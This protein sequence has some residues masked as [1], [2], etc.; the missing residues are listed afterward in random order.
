MLG[1][2]E[3]DEKAAATYKLNHR[4]TCLWIQ[5]IRTVNIV[6]LS[7]QLRLRKGRLDLLAGCPPCQGFSAMRTLNGN[8]SIRDK[9]NDLVSEFLRFVKALRPRALML[10]NVPALAKS[11]RFKEL[12]KSLRELGYDGEYHIL[13]AANFGTPQRR[14]RLI[15]MAGLNFRP[16]FARPGRSARTVRDAIGSLRLAGRSGD[17]IHDIPENRSDE[18]RK[19]IKNI[20]RNGGGRSDLPDREQL[21]CHKLCNGFK[22]VYGRMEWDKPAPTITS[23]C[24]NPS[25]GRFLHPSR[26]RA[27]TV[28]EAALLQGFPES[29]KFDAEH[30]KVALALMVGNALPPPFVAAHA[31]QIKKTLVDRKIGKRS[32]RDGQ[33]YQAPAQL[34][35]ESCQKS[36][37]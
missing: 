31:R 17:A 16:R 33:P 14:R 9:R 12:C 30:G 4:S 27:I 11:R 36:K 25:K 20:P 35:H 21:D 10:E 7:R 8:R 18:V 13:N 2:V 19:R 34:L 24:F 22:D 29:Y 1:A 37:H 28:R 15:Y 32:P 5:D 26:N 6:S 3:N 23:G